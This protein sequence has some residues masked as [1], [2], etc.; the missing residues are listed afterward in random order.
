MLSGWQGPCLR[1]AFPGVQPQA[2]VA[3]HRLPRHTR[4]PGARPFSATS[5]APRR[6]ASAEPTAAVLCCSLG[7]FAARFSTRPMV[8]PKLLEKRAA[9]LPGG[10]P[11]PALDTPTSPKRHHAP[12]SLT[13]SAAPCPRPFCGASGRSS[14]RSTSTLTRTWTRRVQRSAGLSGRSFQEWPLSPVL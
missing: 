3:L 10:G 6:T 1:P 14:H 9:P 8:A 2:Q 5:A 4:L 12:S 11:R 13:S 7:E